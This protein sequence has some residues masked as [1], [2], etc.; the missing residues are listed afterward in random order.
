MSPGQ[1]G[2]ITG[3][4]GR[5][6]GT[7]GTHTRGCPAKILSVYWF[8]S[9]PICAQNSLT[10]IMLPIQEQW[11]KTSCQHTCFV[12]C[13]QAK[14]IEMGVCSL[15]LGYVGSSQTWLFAIFTYGRSL[16]FFCAPFVLFCV[17]AGALFCAHLDTGPNFIH[18]HPPTPTNT[19]LGVGGV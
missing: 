12:T 14:V 4:M 13:S 18:P 9:F 3:Q 11:T 7:D 15:S 8:F 5:V 1:T 10:K 6:P 16:A 2:H 17:L 19:L